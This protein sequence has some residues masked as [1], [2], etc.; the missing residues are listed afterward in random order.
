M[1]PAAF[2][3]F[4]YTDVVEH[5]DAI[6]GALSSGQMPCDAPRPAAQVGKLQQWIDLGM[7]A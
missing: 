7:P 4:D 3:L 5:A 1:M 2:D 6:V